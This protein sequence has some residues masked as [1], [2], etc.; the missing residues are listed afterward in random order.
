MRIG[1][2][3]DGTITRFPEQ[4]KVIAEN[5][6]NNGNNVVTIVTAAAGELAPCDRPAEVVKR[7]SRIGWVSGVHYWDIKCVE[8][9]EKGRCC[10][11]LKLDAIIDDSPEYLEFVRRDSPSTLRLLLL[12]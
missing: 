7:L 2:D 1:I 11:D 3:F 4:L 6:M 12:P 10:A 5:I 8:G 9:H